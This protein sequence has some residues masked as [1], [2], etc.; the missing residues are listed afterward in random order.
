M[1]ART[2]LLA[3]GLLAASLSPAFADSVTA[4]VTNWDATSRTITL[5]D[6]SQFAAIAATVAVPNLKAGDEVT[7]NYEGDENGV[8][9][10]NGITVTTDV[11]KRQVPVPKRG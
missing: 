2:L 3:G 11:A 9:A 1:S 7:V 10:I 8:S 4:T 6:F 5:E